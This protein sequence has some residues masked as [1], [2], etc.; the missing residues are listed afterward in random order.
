MA[1]HSNAKGRIAFSRDSCFSRF[2]F[3]KIDHAGYHFRCNQGVFIG[4]RSQ[5]IPICGHRYAGHPAALVYRQIIEVFQEGNRPARIELIAFHPIAG[6][7]FAA[8]CLYTGFV[9][10][11]AEQTVHIVRMRIHVLGRSPFTPTAIF[12]LHRETDVPRV[13]LAGSRSPIQ[14]RLA[15]DNRGI[16]NPDR[17]RVITIGNLQNRNGSDI[18]CGLESERIYVTHPQTYILATD[19]FIINIS[20][21]RLAA[22]G[23]LVSVQLGQSKSLDPIVGSLHRIFE[24]DGVLV[25]PVRTVKR[26]VETALIHGHS[27]VQY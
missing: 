17:N 24:Y 1:V 25:G 6:R 20:Y 16:G 7:T 22:R 5:N 14:Q 15:S 12:V 10:T 8:E 11:V 21:I 19:A 23:E 26:I 27:I 18:H 9:N 13:F 3:Q 4:S 2:P